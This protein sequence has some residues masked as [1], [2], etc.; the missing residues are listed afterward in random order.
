MFADHTIVFSPEHSNCRNGVEV[1]QKQNL[2]QKYWVVLTMQ[3]G[4]FLVWVLCCMFDWL[5]GVGV[6]V[7]FFLY[8]PK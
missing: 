5:C 3:K 6:F 1:A 8:V 2:Y 7:L 4:A